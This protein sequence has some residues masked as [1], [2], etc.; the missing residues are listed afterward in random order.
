[1]SQTFA[2]Q[3]TPTPAGVAVDEDEE[4]EEEEDEEEEEEDEAVPVPV[5]KPAIKTAPKKKPTTET[6]TPTKKVVPAKVAPKNTPARPLKEKTSKQVTPPTVERKT[7]PAAVPLKKK[8]S[9]LPSATPPPEKK[10]AQPTPE[11]KA[12]PVRADKEAPA[13]PADEETPKHTVSIDEADTPTDK[14]NRTPN[15]FKKGEL[16]SV[17]SLGLL[18]WQNRLGSRIDIERLGPKFYL[19]ITPTVNHTLEIDERDLTMSF[20]VPL[21]L[22]ILDTRGSTTDERFGNAGTFRDADWDTPQDFVK[23]IRFL[24]YGRKE[25]HFY[26]NLNAFRTGS[27]GHGAILRRYNPNLSIDV[28]RVSL[29]LDAFSDYIGAETYLN[30]IAHP[31]LLG[32]LVF[33]KPLSLID[34]DNYINDSNIVTS[35]ERR[36]TSK[37]NPH[38]NNNKGLRR[39]KPPQIGVLCRTGFE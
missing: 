37:M 8:A 32:G 14:K 39:P 20:G 30:D 38:R 19:S 23:L 26:V 35:F 18:P 10:P 31:N 13:E 25:D 22:E 33:V 27:I 16:A 3:P 1:M 28:Q 9:P 7:K 12:A 11:K 5:S 4:D 15:W 34:R 6:V 24:K 21:R 17:G 29:E 36:E 2:L